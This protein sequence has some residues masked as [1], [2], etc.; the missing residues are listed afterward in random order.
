MTGSHEVW[1]SIPHGSTTKIESQRQ[2]ALA[3]F[4]VRPA[5]H[6]HLEVQVLYRPDRGNC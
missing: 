2:T 1:G 6:T 5:W 3:F 4:M